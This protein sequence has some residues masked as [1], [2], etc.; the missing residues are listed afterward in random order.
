MNL[1]FYTQDDAVK[2]FE[3]TL[4]F[5]KNFKDGHIARIPI[6]PRDY[7]T[8]KSLPTFPI[9]FDPIKTLDIQWY[10]ANHSPEYLKGI[11]EKMLGEIIRNIQTFPELSDLDKEVSKSKH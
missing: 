2:F 3:K 11:F 5:L 4:E 6:P 9:D 10:H 7:C 1:E 8:A